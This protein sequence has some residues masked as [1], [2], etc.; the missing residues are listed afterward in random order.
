MV[1][2]IG[3]GDESSYLSNSALSGYGHYMTDEDDENSE[4]LAVLTDNYSLD[5]L[6]VSLFPISLLNEINLIIDTYS[7]LSK[8]ILE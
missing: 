4:G 7:V 3:L 5:A 8:I 6:K 2:S 1:S